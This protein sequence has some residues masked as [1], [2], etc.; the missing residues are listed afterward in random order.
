[1]LLVKAIPHNLYEN[2]IQNLSKLSTRV[3]TE[4][5]GKYIINFLKS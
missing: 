1:M 4:C 2:E 3:A 5:H